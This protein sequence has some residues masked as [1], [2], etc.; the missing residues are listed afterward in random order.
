M[1]ED[2]VGQEAH[3][4]VQVR[5]FGLAV[6]GHVFEQ[7]DL[8]AQ[9]ALGRGQGDVQAAAVLAGLELRPSGLHGGG[10]AGAVEAADPV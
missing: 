3:L 2:F 5:L 10:Q 9:F 7:V 1:V 8:V 4:L 6:F